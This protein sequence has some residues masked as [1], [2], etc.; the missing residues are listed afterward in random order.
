VT[1][2]ET[3]FKGSVRSVAKIMTLIENEDPLAAAILEQL[4]LH[5]G[6][7]HVIGITGFPGSGK[8]TLVNQ[9]T[10]YLRHLGM[11]VGVGQ[12][13]IDIA[14]LA[15]TT[16]VV[17]VPGLGDD[18]QAIKAGIMEI[19]DLLVINKADK[20][21]QRIKAEVLR[22]FEK[23]LFRKAMEKINRHGI[24][25]KWTRC[26]LQHEK[27]PAKAAAELTKAVLNG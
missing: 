10:K 12:S 5:S 16:L 8:S 14:G 17:C 19:G 11:T 24:L 3:F 27:S 26:V 1:L 23:E 6:N 7:A 2:V 25:D 18:I 22:L 9:M 21:E 4:F 20:R 15:D 13:E